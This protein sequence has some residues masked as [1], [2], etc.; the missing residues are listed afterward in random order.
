VTL[1]WILTGQAAQPILEGLPTDWTH[2]H[3]IFSQPTTAEEAARM[4]GDPRYW[5][6]W[7]RQNVVRVLLPDAE[8]FGGATWGGNR[9]GVRRVESQIHADWSQT[10]GAGG[11]VGA[12]NFAAKYSFG[13]TTAN[14]GNA[15]NPDFVVFSTGLKGSLTQASII[16]YDN[17]YTPGCTGTVPSVYW[18]YNT[19][20]GD[21]I[22]TSPVFSRD[23]SQI[24]FVQTNGTA[25]SLVLLKWAASTGTLGAPATPA[26]MTTIALK[27]SA[28]ATTNDTT[29]SVFYD[30]ISDTAWVGDASGSLHRFN[31]VFN[32]APAES[33]SPWPVQ[34]STATHPALSSPVYDGVSGNVF[35]EDQGGYLYSVVASGVSAGTVTKSVQVDSGPSTAALVSGPI[36]DKIAE[37]VYAFASND[38][39]ANC[40]GPGCSAVY[41]FPATFTAATV[42]LEIAVGT[43]SATANPLYD[44]AFDNEF[45]SSPTRTGNLYVCGDT[46]VNPMLYQVTMVAGAFGV[47]EPV[48]PL[49]P[50]GDHVACSPVS[51]IV[52]PTASGGTAPEERV[53]FGVTNFARPT[54][55][56][57][58][59]C[60]QSFISMPWLAG[61]AYQVGQ[62]ILAFRPQN[63]TYYVEVAIGAGTSGPSVPTWVAAAGTVTTTDGTVR[64]INQGA[65]QFTVMAGWTANH[66]YALHT[67]IL[68]SNGNV[69]VVTTAGTSGGTQP[70]NWATTAGGTTVDPALPSPPAVTW[71]NA[72]PL[73][74]AALLATGGTSGIIID[75]TVSTGTLAGASEL[76]FTPLANEPCPTVS[77]GCAVQASQS[78]LK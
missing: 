31:P 8:A 1:G 24:A 28:G 4:A 42:P 72:G 51:D 57:P 40:G 43:S 52:N 34:V 20:T 18:A 29:S 37:K 7:Y 30:Y 15:T 17:L 78:A 64:W 10:L 70:T 9:H 46:G 48:A 41:Q 50:A 77:S 19:G 5:Q 65:A 22:L 12:G 63:H 26:V 45:Y 59:G 60:A 27:S 54:A 58:H 6:Q 71:T 21:Q 14:C 44:G 66:P 69:E 32:A 55:C 2:R 35:V 56:T 47:S 53:F 73:P 75:N 3:V 11:T 38:G 16:A 74:S 76:Y 61:T 49:T 39:T 62:E 67:R 68:D 23:G 33:G 36:L 13:I 25:A